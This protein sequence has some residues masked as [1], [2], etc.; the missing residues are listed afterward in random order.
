M[1]QEF[2]NFY[3][4]KNAKFKLYRKRKCMY[5]Y[6][7]FL[8]IFPIFYFVISI[9]LNLILAIGVRFKWPF[10]NLFKGYF[11]FRN[12]G[13]NVE[14]VNRKNSWK[15]LL[16]K[17]VK[18]TFFEILT[19]CGIFNSSC[20]WTLWNIRFIQWFVILDFFIIFYILIWNFLLFLFNIFLII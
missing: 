12:I 10:R 8:V 3:R 13:V 6:L 19:Y 15:L 20:Q 9:S 17:F 5:N 14:L 18:I 1:K 16:E 4:V 7:Y 11:F 2:V